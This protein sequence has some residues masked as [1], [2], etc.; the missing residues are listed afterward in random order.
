MAL[1][2]RTKVDFA[3]DFGNTIILLTL[4]FVTIYPMYYVLG[5]SVSDSV[6]LLASPGIL[7]IPKGFSLGAF[8]LAFSH[9]LLI[10]GYKNILFILIV[11]L[12]IN[13]TMT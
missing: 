4:V 2:K 3:F 8:R 13:M 7:W 1:N 11:A 5:A 9:P 12:P 6:K 10:S